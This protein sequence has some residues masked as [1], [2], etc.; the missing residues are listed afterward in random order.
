[1]ETNDSEHQHIEIITEYKEGE[2]YNNTPPTITEVKDVIKR[3]KRRKAP[4]PDGIT[5]DIV[6][7]LGEEAI[8]E[9][10]KRVQRWWEKEDI[11]RR[12]KSK[13]RT[14]IQKGRHKQ[15]RKL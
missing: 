3:F 9:I 4:G 13:N 2:V 14:N 5:T 10:R 6:T 15:I 8:E 7:E 12:T 1:M 11:H